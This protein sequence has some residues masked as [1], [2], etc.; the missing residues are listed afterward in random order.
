MKQIYKILF[1]ISTTGF[2]LI[3]FALALAAATFI[4]NSY[5]SEAARAIVYNSW[6]LEVILI[7]LAAN[8]IANV[9][10]YKLYKKKKLTLGIFHVAFLLILLGAGVTRYFGREGEMHIR[11]GQSLFGDGDSGAMVPVLC[12]IQ[13]REKGGILQVPGIFHFKESG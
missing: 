5:G 12:R 7:L 6:W 2:L 9:I 13:W 11:Q 4:E 8:M 10:K 3:V 1:S